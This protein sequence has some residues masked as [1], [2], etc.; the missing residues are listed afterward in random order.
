MKRTEMIRAVCLGS[1]CLCIAWMLTACSNK[2]DVELEI[3]NGDVARQC[4]TGTVVVVETLRELTQVERLEAESRRLVAEAGRT[5]GDAWSASCNLCKEICKLPKEEALPLLDR[6]LE[7][8]IEQPVTNANKSA[9]LARHEDLFQIVLCS[10]IA[11]QGLRENSFEEWDKVF[12]FFAKY[13]DEITAEKRRI[14]ELDRPQTNLYYKYKHFRRL[15]DLQLYVENL[16]HNAR[17]VF[18]NTLSK[19]LTEEQKADILRRLDEVKKYSVP[20][21][22]SPYSKK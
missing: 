16:V 15:H 18:T 10:F 1:V 20:P 6:L 2:N 9:T 22:D 7:M 21:P 5:K 19:G 11:S 8:A 4:P 3:N 13:T 17:T 12:R 14:K